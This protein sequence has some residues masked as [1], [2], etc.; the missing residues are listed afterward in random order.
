MFAKKAGSTTTSTI[1]RKRVFIFVA[2]AYGLAIAPYVVVF[3]GGERFSSYRNVASAQAGILRVVLMFAPTIAHIAT[4]LL[5]G[6]GWSKTFLRPNFYQGRWRYYLAAWLLPPAATIAGGAI[7]YLLFPGQFDPSMTAYRQLG[8]SA[9]GSALKPWAF[10][11]IQVG[12]ALVR[13]FTEAL[14]LSFGEEFG[15]RAYLLPKLMPLGPRKAVVLAGAIWAV[16][17]W[18]SIMTG[19]NYGLSYCGAP[20]AGPLLFVLVM[21]FPSAL[22]AWVTLRSGSVWPA[23]IA[24]G[25]GNAS[26]KL[27]WFF[28]SRAANPLIGPGVQGIIGSLGYAALA[29]LISFSPR[30][31]AQPAPAPVGA[32]LTENP[33]A[34]GKAAGQ[35]E[36]G[37]A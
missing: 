5:T 32:A 6:E 14:L 16:W 20:V 25:A 9:I 37:T 13:P 12:I 24:H 2:I 18:P 3:A 26:N 35:A 8:M 7:Y 34:P 11:I 28:L 1:D 10:F 15:W 36:L 33:G 27:M 31:L 22:Y 23:A 29:V 19:F 4:R 17:H 30:A 21:I